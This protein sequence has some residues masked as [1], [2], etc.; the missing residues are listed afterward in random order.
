MR[1]YRIGAAVALLMVLGIATAAAQDTG[2]LVRSRVIVVAP[3]ASSDPSGLDVGTDATIELDVTRH[4]SPLLALELAVATL[5][6]ELRVGDNSLGSVR[7][8]PPTL[9]LQVRP[10]RDG[11][12]R[13]YLGAGANLAIFYAHSGGLETLDLGSSLGW[14]LQGG[15]DVPL[16]RRGVFNVDLKY[17]GVQ[18]EIESGGSTVYQLEINPWVIGAG[19]GYRF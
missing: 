6:H 7:L 13:P 19:L 14:A 10:L 2:W 12:F 11:R 17:L 8:L 1:S 16:G 4:L 3:D 18:T 9:L 15:V 5:G